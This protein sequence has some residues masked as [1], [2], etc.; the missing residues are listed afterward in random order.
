MA[1]TYPKKPSNLIITLDRHAGFFLTI[2]PPLTPGIAWHIGFAQEG[3]SKAVGTNGWNDDVQADGTPVASIGNCPEH[4]LL[5]HLNLFPFPPFQPN[6][7]IPVLIIFSSSKNFLSVGSVLCKKGPVSVSIPFVKVLGV[8]LACNDPIP[9][10]TDIV[11]DPCSTVVLGFTL[12][13]LLAAL[14]RWAFDVLIA[15]LMKALGKIAG[16]IGKKIAAK[17]GPAIANR[18]TSGLLN[19]LGTKL[20]NY[21]LGIKGP[22]GFLKSKLLGMMDKLGWNKVYQKTASV[23]GARSLLG[24]VGPAMDKFFGMGYLDKALG[25][26][27]AQNGQFVSIADSL[28]KSAKLDTPGLLGQGAKAGKWAFDGAHPYSPDLPTRIGGWLDGRAEMIPG[29]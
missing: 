8:N 13:D 23:E 24:P 16:A 20:T 14:M 28:L 19:K 18:F 12:G 6:I 5:P 21:G 2:I 11:I 9:L 10:P 1:D 27:V 17:V 29:H 25:T 7:L 3:W 22:P 26:K 15:L 4:C